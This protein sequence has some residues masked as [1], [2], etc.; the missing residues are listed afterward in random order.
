V[1]GISIIRSRKIQRSVHRPRGSRVILHPQT[2]SLA[3]GLVYHRSHIEGRETR[4]RFKRDFNRSSSMARRS[5]NRNVI[6]GALNLFEVHCEV[7]RDAAE[8]LMATRDP[9][10]T[11]H[12]EACLQ[13]RVF[14]PLAGCCYATTGCLSQITKG[15]KLDEKTRQ[16]LS[17]TM[18]RRVADLYGASCRAK[19]PLST[20]TSNR[21]KNVARTKFS[22]EKENAGFCFCFYKTLF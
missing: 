18:K 7:R 17:K 22:K 16:T 12:R 6:T 19:V 15:R 20:Y 11:L 5:R 21:G 4:R 14:L 13:L 2:V 9:P 1:R 8:V 10:S 3:P